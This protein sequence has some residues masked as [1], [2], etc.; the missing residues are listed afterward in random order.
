V[1]NWIFKAIFCIIVG[2]SFWSWDTKHRHLPRAEGGKPRPTDRLATVPV[3]GR[4]RLAAW[5]ARTRFTLQLAGAFVLLESLTATSGRLWRILVG[6]ALL[7]ISVVVRSRR[8]H[9][10]WSARRRSG[11]LTGHR[12]ALA[13]TLAAFSAAAAVSFAIFAV[14]WLFA[15]YLRS[16]A[17]VLPS[18]RLDI[19]L[20]ASGSP[21]R[22]LA[23]EPVSVLIVDLFALAVMAALVVPVSYT[24]AR[25]VAALSRS[26]ICATSPTTTSRC[27][28]A[29]CRGTRWLSGLPSTGWNDSRR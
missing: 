18:G 10:P 17:T 22:L 26:F 14:L 5:P 25:R 15:L 16:S 19:S 29:G 9:R 7:A 8:L 12:T 6:V 24:A 20:M 27:R 3:T 13:A 1:A 23:L 21:Y 4:A 11:V 28:R 2:L